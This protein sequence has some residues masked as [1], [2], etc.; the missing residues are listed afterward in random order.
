[1]DSDCGG[2][3]GAHGW[4]WQPA[5]VTVGMRDCE[6][7]E[8]ARALGYGRGAIGSPPGEG[9]GSKCRGD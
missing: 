6:V 5:P 1:M 7:R 3:A 4:V 9:D 2:R 8:R